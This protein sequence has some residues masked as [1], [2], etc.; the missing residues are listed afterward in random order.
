MDILFY[1]SSA[2]MLGK[3]DSKIFVLRSSNRFFCSIFSNSEFV[4]TKIMHDLYQICCEK[5]FR[6][7][8]VKKPTP[9]PRTT[10]Y[11]Y[12]VMAKEGPQPPPP[13][14]SA[15]TEEPRTPTLEKQM[16]PNPLSPRSFPQSTVHDQSAPEIKRRTTVNN[17][18][19]NGNQ[20]LRDRSGTL[21]FVEHFEFTQPVSSMRSGNG[22]GHG[23]GNSTTATIETSVPP[24]NGQNQSRSSEIAEERHEH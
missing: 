9:P 5:R 15:E 21:P 7:N 10:L 8:P 1:V 23:H 18:N 13:P 20:G 19:G 17:G 4:A 14:P 11:K 3:L 22:H 16:L 2:P 12:L 24:R 6:G